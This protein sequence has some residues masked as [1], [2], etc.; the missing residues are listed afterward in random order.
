[1]IEIDKYTLNVGDICLFK[2]NEIDETIQGEVLSIEDCKYQHFLNGKECYEKY[3]NKELSE[4]DFICEDI[5]NENVIITVYGWLKND[6][7]NIKE[8]L[9]E[10]K[11]SCSHYLIYKYKT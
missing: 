4:N 2:H 1:M 8:Q 7:W 6:N 3:L 10:I 9:G 11:F 5:I